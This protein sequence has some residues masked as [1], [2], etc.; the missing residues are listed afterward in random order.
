MPIVYTREATLGVEEFI[1]VL[2]RAGLAARRLDDLLQRA[3]ERARCRL[4]P[5]TS[6]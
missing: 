4:R 1:D 3:R 6:D 2:V 5:S